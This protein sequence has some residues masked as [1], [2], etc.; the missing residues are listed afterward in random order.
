MAEAVARLRPIQTALATARV[1]IIFQS[2]SFSE[3]R[4]NLC[5][6]LLR[7]S[8]NVKT[9]FAVLFPYFVLPGPISGICGRKND[10]FSG[11]ITLM[12]PG[13]LFS[14]RKNRLTH[15]PALLCHKPDYGTST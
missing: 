10:R 11:R 1:L 2:V 13:H 12:Y 15:V 7:L 3:F 5:L 8:L 9:Y 14:K 4:P 6:T